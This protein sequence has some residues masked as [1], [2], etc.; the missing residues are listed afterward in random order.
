[1][2]SIVVG[3]DARQR[4]VVRDLTEPYAMPFELIDNF[5]HEFTFLGSDGPRLFFKTDVDAPRRR[6]IAID[7]RAPKKKDWQE[8][9]PQAENTLT[10]VSLVGD[11]FIALYLQDASTEVKLFSLAASSSR[12]CNCRASARRPVSR[13]SGTTASGPTG[14]RS[15]VFP[16]WPRRRAS[17][18]SIWPR[19]KAASSA[20]PRPSS[21]PSV[22]K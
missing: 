2:I 8:L 7:L 18:G 12:T 21:T 14:R 6:V 22:M 4:I 16:A 10:D 20:G 1:M 3:T 11:R 9:I 13:A 19:A 17:I 15:T 5:E